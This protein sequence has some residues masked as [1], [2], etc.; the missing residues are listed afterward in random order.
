MATSINRTQQLAEAHTKSRFGS[1]ASLQAANVPTKQHNVGV[2]AKKAESKAKSASSTAKKVEKSA[3]KKATAQ[4]SAAKK[5][6]TK[7]S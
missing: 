4:K 5:T 7:K 1:K 6:A 3:P 2:E